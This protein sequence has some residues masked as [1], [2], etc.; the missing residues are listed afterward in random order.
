VLQGVSDFLWTGRAL[1][2]RSVGEVAVMPL[3]A[4]L[5]VFPACIVMV[6]PWGRDAVEESARS[7]EQGSAL[8]MARVVTLAAVWGVLLLAIAGVRNPRYGQPCVAFT[9]V[10]VG[11]VLRG[12]RS[13]FFI[14]RRRIASVM[15]LGRPSV[16][17]ALLLAVAVVVVHDPFGLRRST[18]GRSAGREIGA[19]LGEPGEVWSDHMVEARPEVLWYAKQEA[20]REGVAL[21]PKW[22]PGLG[23]RAEMPA[24]GYLLLRQDAESDETEAYRRAGM[25]DRLRPVTFGRVHKFGYVLY[26]VDSE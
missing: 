4:L 1:D 17:A 8:R 5:S 11:Y 16:L 19:A 14:V 9:P 2:A 20:L 18:S 12:W 6:F 25:L 21:A 7:E 26:R 23:A 24:A 15:M 13:D 22:K 3:L 10:L